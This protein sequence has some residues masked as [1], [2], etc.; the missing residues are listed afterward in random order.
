[1]TA[2]APTFGS[3]TGDHRVLEPAGATPLDATRLDAQPELWDGEL[4]LDLE[5]LVLPARDLRAW[6]ERLAADPEVLRA[7]FAEAV[8]ERGGVGEDAAAG[9]LVGTV[10]AVGTAHPHPVDV[11]ERVAVAVPAG[12][13]PLLAAPTADWDGGRTVTLHG[14]AVVP[15]AAATVPAADAPAALAALLVDVADV[16]AGLASGAR[17]VV[18]GP[19]RGGGAVALAAAVAQHRHVTAVVRSLA[20]A[21]LARAAGAD[22]VAVADVADPVGAVAHLAEVVGDGSAPRFDLAVVADPAAA[23]LAVR[24]A[25]SVQVLTERADVPATVGAVL[26]HAAALGAGPAVHAGRARVVDRGAALRDLAARS[27]VLL[28]TLR[29]QAGVGAL[30]NVGP[31]DGPEPAARDDPAAAS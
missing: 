27:S 19:D 20:M 13:V 26:R 12:A 25:P 7:A 1:M 17:T 10:A 5:A 15:A 9:T 2:R 28:V 31:H 16:P 4:R 18:L 14:H 24:L 8:A 29:W 30:P 3:P 6:Q 11:G 23:A 22:A 21:R